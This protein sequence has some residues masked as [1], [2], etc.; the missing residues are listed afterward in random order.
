MRQ[1]TSKGSAKAFFLDRDA[2]LNRLRIA[3]QEALRLFPEVAEVLLFGSLA[4][5]THTGLSDIDLA[6]VLA[7]SS[8]S[9]DPLERARP[10]H[11]HFQ[12]R[13]ALG[14]DIVVFSETERPGMRSFLHNAI[15]LA[16]R[17]K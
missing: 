4:D 11:R 8:A 12:Q 7:A 10:F 16:A 15:T 1:V 13:L 5:D 9:V 2:V 17:A 6:V 14:V 3:A